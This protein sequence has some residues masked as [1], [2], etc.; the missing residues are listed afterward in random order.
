MPVTLARLRW[1]PGDDV[2]IYSSAGAAG[3]GWVNPGD[4]SAIDAELAAAEA[5][6]PGLC[7]AGNLSF[8]SSR[9]LSCCEGLVSLCDACVEIAI[10][11]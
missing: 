3:G 6:V 5:R 11:L 2:V 7:S 8:E 4:E 9:L 10:L 1:P